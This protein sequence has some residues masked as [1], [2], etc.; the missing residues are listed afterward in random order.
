MQP[1]ENAA[2]AELISSY[3]LPV[4]ISINH[5]SNGR[6]FWSCVLRGGGKDL[7]HFPLKLMLWC[8]LSQA[9]TA[10]SDMLILAT[11]GVGSWS[12]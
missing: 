4:K 1:V 11:V 12:K 8:G 9:Q 7:A 3:V 6:R 10:V 2:S 5:L